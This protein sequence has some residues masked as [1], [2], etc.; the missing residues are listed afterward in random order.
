MT[1]K[2]V[3]IYSPLQISLQI[4]GKGIFDQPLTEG[5]GKGAHWT[6]GEG[7]GDGNSNGNGIGGG[8]GRGTDYYDGTRSESGHGNGYL[9]GYGYSPHDGSGRSSQ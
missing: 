9:Y 7:L 8:H 2:T 6:D 5:D 3:G 1:W 4:F